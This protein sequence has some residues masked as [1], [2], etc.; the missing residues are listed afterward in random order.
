VSTF[1]WLCSTL[2]KI[3]KDT[4]IVFFLFQNMILNCKSHCYF[5]K[6]KALSVRKKMLRFGI[7]YIC[8]FNIKVNTF[9]YNEKT[10]TLQ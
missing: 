2:I 3:L 6:Y 8:A 5:L 1:I 4:T 10:K 9:I 7:F